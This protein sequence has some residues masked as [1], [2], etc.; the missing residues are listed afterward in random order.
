MEEHRI[1]CHLIQGFFPTLPGV[2]ILDR[3]RATVVCH[4][5]DIRQHHSLKTRYCRG[6]HLGMLPAVRLF[7]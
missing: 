1:L 7:A 4:K 5:G 2:R 6:D 3:P